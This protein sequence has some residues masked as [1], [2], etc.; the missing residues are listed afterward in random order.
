MEQ[1]LVVF[2]L[3][4]CFPWCSQLVNDHFVNFKI[5]G[6]FLSA[7]LL[8]VKIYWVV[9]FVCKNF[10]STTTSL[11]RRA[12]ESTSSLA[13][14]SLSSTSLQSTMLST[15]PRNPGQPSASSPTTLSPLALCT[16]CLGDKVAFNLLADL[17]GVG[18]F[19]F[20]LSR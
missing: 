2:P 19:A 18:S 20:G 12:L 11:P 15:N 7:M 10:A 17:S 3:R 14:A 9:S 13:L 5:Y 16:Q 8:V 4:C 6:F 1:L